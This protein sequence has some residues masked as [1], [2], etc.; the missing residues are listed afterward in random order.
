MVKRLIRKV[1]ISILY[2]FRHIDIKVRHHWYKNNT[3]HLNIFQ[4]KGYWSYGKNREQETIEMFH[5]IIK[6]NDCILDIGAHIGYM[7]IIFSEIASNGQVYSFEPNSDTIPYLEKNISHRSNCKII[8]TGI[9]NING[10][11]DF[12]KENL[13]GQNSTLLKNFAV[14]EDNLKNTSLKT[15]DRR[16]VKVD[17]QTIDNFSTENNLNPDFIKIDIEGAEYEALKGG[18]S[19]F[20]KTNCNLMVELNIKEEIKE[21]IFLL[22]PLN[23][24][25]FQNGEI[26]S[27]ED[28][29]TGNLFCI[30]Q[31][32]F[33]AI[34]I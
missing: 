34:N 20:K 14:F 29:Q 16:K 19:T 22:E 24:K 10:E 7:S 17:V 25:Y 3:L 26:V 5:K 4:H 30:N 32:T 9:S 6:P 1:A 31:K 2:I 21:I 8:N 15:I 33:S 18:L 13:T 27:S 11:M 28:I 23:Y 12:Y